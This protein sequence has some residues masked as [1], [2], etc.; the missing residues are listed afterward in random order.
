[1][2]QTR[3]IIKLN[4]ENIL[5]SG[6]KDITLTIL[7]TV[8]KHKTREDHHKKRKEKRISKITI[9][10]R[11]TVQMKVK[12]NNP[13]GHSSTSRHPLWPRS[14]YIQYSIYS[15]AFRSDK[16]TLSETSFK[17]IAFGWAKLFA[18]SHVLSKVPY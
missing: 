13:R 1:M 5:Q 3:S 18:Y 14:T 10:D 4:F 11:K 8:V 2:S 7:N 16:I 12:G 17:L 9:K 15:V 6:Q